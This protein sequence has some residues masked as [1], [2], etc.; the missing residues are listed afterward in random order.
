M[1]HTH[2]AAVCTTI[3]RLQRVQNNDLFIYKVVIYLDQVID[4]EADLLH[5]L[6]DI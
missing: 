4:S 6:H 5:M 1:S 2:I 3:T